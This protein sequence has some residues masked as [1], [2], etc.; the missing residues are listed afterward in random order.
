MLT[1]PTHLGSA[2]RDARE[3]RAAMEKEKALTKRACIG[4]RRSARTAS[5]GEHVP[6][7]VLGAHT[8]ATI[9]ELAT[10]VVHVHAYQGRARRV[11]RAD[12]LADDPIARDPDARA[13]G[14]VLK[15]RKLGRRQLHRL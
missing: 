7:A 11:M 2:W 5:D 8:P 3:L 10:D 13:L 12:H 9:P 4:A 6:A 15:D 14:E 1:L